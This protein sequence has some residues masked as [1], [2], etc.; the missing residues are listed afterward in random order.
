ML[1]AAGYLRFAKWTFVGGLGLGIKTGVLVLGHEWMGLDYLAATVLAVE[2]A[3]LHNFCWHQCWTWRD[4]PVDGLS[5]A[6][7]LMRFHAGTAMVAFVVNVVFMRLLVEFAGMHYVFAS[8]LCAPAVG[9][10][11]FVIAEFLIFGQP[12]CAPPAER[13]AFFRT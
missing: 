10:V 7:R 8:L 12:V 9:L 2:A 5:V 6:V 11:N 3:I 1:A 13:T 4:R